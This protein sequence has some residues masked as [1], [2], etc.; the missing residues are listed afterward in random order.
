[1]PLKKLKFYIF[2]SVL[3]LVMSL[4]IV[5][6]IKTHFSKGLTQNESFSLEQTTWLIDLFDQAIQQ[7]MEPSKKR[8]TPLRLWMTA[9]KPAFKAEHLHMGIKEINRTMQQQWEEMSIDD[10]SEWMIEAG[11]ILPTRQPIEE[12][13]Q[14]SSYQNWK[15]DSQQIARLVEIKQAYPS[16]SYSQNL[17]ILKLEWDNIDEV[18]RN[19]WDDRIEPIQVTTD[20]SVR[21]RKKGPYMHFKQDP[22]IIQE[23]MKDYSE[24]S[25]SDI[26]NAFKQK[27]KALGKEGQLHWTTL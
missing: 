7:S 5:D 25:K 3:T 26:T 27:W 9:T 15:N 14:R 8:T 23:V 24:A 17:S 11:E 16:N 12:R 22:A 21:I 4:K 13:S 6:K 19:T 10:K 1:M 20:G 2:T 18:T